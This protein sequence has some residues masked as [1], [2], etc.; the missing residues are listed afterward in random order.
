MNTRRLMY[1]FAGA[2]CMTGLRAVAMSD[3]KDYPLISIDGKFNCPF[4]PREGGTA[5]LQLAVAAPDYPRADRRP[6]NLA[7]VL[8]RSGSMGEQSKIQNAKAAL[9]ALIDDLGRDD[10]LSIVIYDDVVEVLRPAARVGSREEIKRLV[11][12]V[13]PRGW[14][15]LGGGMVE[16]FHQAERYASSDCV[17]RVVLLSDGLANRGETDPL[18]LKRIARRYRSN[19]IS[20]TTMGVGLD[21]N[22]NLMV[23]LSESG[24]G[25][26]Y[27]IE[28]ARNLA[29]ILRREFNLMACV[30]AQNASIDLTLA[31]GVTIID[32]IGYEFQTEGNRV[33]IPLG[34][35]YGGDRREIT[36]E[37]R[38]CGGSGSLSAVRGSLRYA[39]DGSR[40]RSSRSFSAVL[41]Y[42]K[43]LARIERSR[44]KDIQ[45]KADIAV[46]TRSV[47]NALKALDEGK[48]QSAVDELAAASRTLSASPVAAQGGSAGQ[49]LLD[50]RARVDSYLNLLKESRGETNKAKKTIQY[51]NYRTQKNK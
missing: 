12:C 16:G 36:V 3:P 42:T 44:D 28:S 17:N 6:M 46:S 19:S 32:V 48:Q 33:T 7:V 24:G 41:C 39:T 4:I 10:I 11:D 40:V 13:A 1:L 27:F 43:D 26:Y 14:T 31:G 38:V 23:A 15:N 47:D 21:Y 37:L 30:A 34:D 51:E 5:Y 22:E 9:D 35:L 29:S 8:D 20:L 18:E 25:N 45:A 2:L 50:Q 49:A